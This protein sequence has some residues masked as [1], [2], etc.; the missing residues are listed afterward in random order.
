MSEVIIYIHAKCSTCRKAMAWLN[1]SGVE[2]SPIDI[3]T[4]PP[5]LDEMR[6]IQRLSGLPVRKLFNTS[7]RAYRDGGWSDRLP[8]LTDEDALSAL[9]QNGR[10]IK[11]PLLVGP[12]FALAGFKA[13]VY[14]VHLR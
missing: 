6:R 4:S 2:V 9:C 12:N 10:L 7:G 1:K 8:E 14:G 3:L 11:R 5:T 13:S